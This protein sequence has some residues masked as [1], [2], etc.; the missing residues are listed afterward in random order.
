MKDYRV[1]ITVRNNRILFYMKQMGY[2]TVAD[3]CN[4]NPSLFQTSVG[5][6]INLKS[7]PIKKGGNWTEQALKLME[8]L[9]CEPDDLW[10]DAQRNYALKMNKKSVELAE[11]EVKKLIVPVDPE[12][13]SIECQ[14]NEI[15]KATLETLT[16]REEAVLQMRFG[17]KPY[18]REHTYTEIG[19]DLG[20]C[21]QRVHQVETRALRKLRHPTRSRGLKEF[22]QS[23]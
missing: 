9:C 6:L 19:K 20:I 21:G 8:V 23:D 16:P 22:N 13:L 14:K 2:N 10:S 4:N 11:S 17:L 3:L 5:A 7:K 1:E 12:I 15:I 18:F